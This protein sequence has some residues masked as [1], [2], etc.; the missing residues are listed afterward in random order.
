MKYGRR[1]K[2]VKPPLII[3]GKMTPEYYK[4]YYNENKVEKDKHKQ[5]KH[6]GIE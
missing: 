3:E 1:L 2:E 6:C 5:I 4:K